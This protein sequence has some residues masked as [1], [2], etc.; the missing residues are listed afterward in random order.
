MTHLSDSLQAFKTA[1]RTAL[2]L[3][4]NRETHLADAAL[5]RDELSRSYAQLMGSLGVYSGERC[6]EPLTVTVVPGGL[7]EAVFNYGWPAN[8][9]GEKLRRGAYIDPEVP[10]RDWV[11]FANPLQRLPRL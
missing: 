1:L 4:D 5:A 8:F 6:T 9:G 3:D 2:R 7:G 10:A 11:V